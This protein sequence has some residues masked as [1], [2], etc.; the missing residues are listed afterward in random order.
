MSKNGKKEVLVVVQNMLD[1]CGL[2]ASQMIT[3]CVTMFTSM[4]L[5]EK[6]ST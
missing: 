2:M 3:D 1:G 5:K 4:N 6:L